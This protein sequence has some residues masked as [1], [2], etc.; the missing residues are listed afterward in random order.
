MD[1]DQ[2][3]AFQTTGTNSL[4]LRNQIHKAKE[5]Y[6]NKLTTKCYQLKIHRTFDDDFKKTV[7]NFYEREIV[8]PVQVRIDLIEDQWRTLDFLEILQSVNPCPIVEFGRNELFRKYS[9]LLGQKEDVTFR[10]SIV[11]CGMFED[12]M[13]R[14]GWKIGDT[15]DIEEDICD[16]VGQLLMRVEKQGRSSLLDCMQSAMKNIEVNGDT[17]RTLLLR[18]K[19]YNGLNLAC[20]LLEQMILDNKDIDVSWMR[21]VFAQFIDL[22]VQLIIEPDYQVDVHWTLTY[23]QNLKSEWN[24]ADVYNLT[25]NG[26]LM[27][28]EKQKKFH[29]YLMIIRNFALLSV[30]EYQSN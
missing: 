26:L 16:V 5:Q 18:K 3:N 7:R 9:T 28:H 4:K 2:W 13:R 23:L 17:L 11:L 15:H 29:R 27:F 25:K 30:I 6:H 10:R 14:S 21:I 1:A 12:L 8:Q 22:V 20:V 19:K 24:V